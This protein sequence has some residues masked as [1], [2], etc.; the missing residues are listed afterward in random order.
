MGWMGIWWI[1]VAALLAVV[2]WT[3]LKTA[4]RP[5]TGRGESPEDIVERRYANGEIDREI[6][7]RMLTDLK[8]S[9]G[10]QP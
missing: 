7:Q 4:R 1:L 9:G 6:Y 5:T 8:G 3:L 10:R 2:V